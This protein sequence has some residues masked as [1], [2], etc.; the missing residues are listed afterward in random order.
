MASWLSTFDRVEVI[1]SHAAGEPTRVVVSGN[2]DLGDGDIRERLRIFRTQYDAF[3]AGVVLEPRECDVVVGAL[4]CEP[5]NPSSAG[6]VIF[7]SDPGSRADCWFPKM[8]LCTRL[9]RPISFFARQKSTAP[10]SCEVTR[11]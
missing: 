7:F 1:D 11:S 5:D 8:L 6:A 2:P 10:H 3:R 9:P 4:L